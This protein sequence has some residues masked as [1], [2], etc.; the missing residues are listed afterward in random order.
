I[1]GRE[2][3]VHIDFDPSQL[4][5]RGVT[6]SHIAQA[7]RAQLVDVSAGDIPMG[8]RR[9]VVRTQLTPTAVEEL[10]NAVLKTSADGTPVLLGHVATVRP[11]LRK[12]EAI[13]LVNGEP[14]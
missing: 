12:A 11:G 8:K 2:Q 1:A 6:V 10:E 3:E 13:G 14:S 5:S 7:V 4:A 9:Y